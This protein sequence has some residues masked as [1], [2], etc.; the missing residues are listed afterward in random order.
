MGEEEQ[1]DLGIAEGTYIS[2]LHA[3][4]LEVHEI[5]QE[6]EAVGFPEKMLSQIIAH[7]L[8]DIINDRPTED[9]SESEFEDEEDDGGGDDYME[10]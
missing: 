2:P 10:D 1:N 9:Y 4:S 8:I 7:M 5:Y 6:L 3:V